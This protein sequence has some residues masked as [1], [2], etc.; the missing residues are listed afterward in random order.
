MNRDE[1]NRIKDAVLLTVAEQ[2]SVDPF[3]LKESDRKRCDLTVD[4]V[5][6]LIEADLR[7]RLAGE[8]EAMQASEVGVW[9]EPA[10]YTRAKTD[11]ARIVRGAT[12]DTDP[13][14]DNTTKRT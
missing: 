2:M 12:A 10:N 6:P 5:A 13:A 3:A 7:E 1:L 8:I 14:P 9:S 11:A 4:A